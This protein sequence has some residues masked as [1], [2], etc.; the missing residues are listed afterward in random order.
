[1]ANPTNSQ[2]LKRVDKNTIKIEKM[3]ADIEKIKIQISN[4]HLKLFEHDRRFEILEERTALI[5]KLYD[6]VDKI[7]KELIEGR[8]ERMITMHKLNNHEDRII[9]LENRA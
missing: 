7:L 3:S 6:N 8:Q 9:Y 2:I 4:I 1:M 5:P